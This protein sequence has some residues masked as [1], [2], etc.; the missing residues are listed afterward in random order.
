MLQLLGVQQLVVGHTPQEKGRAGVRCGGK[1]LLLDTGMSSGMMDNP[2][3]AWM[4]QSVRNG[5]GTDDAL[6]QEDSAST[7]HSNQFEAV[8]VQDKTSD[9]QRQSQHRGTVWSAVVYADGL[10]QPV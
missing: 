3:S 4:C 1:L 2:A 9:K 8:T 7:D 6:Q 10:V 5:G